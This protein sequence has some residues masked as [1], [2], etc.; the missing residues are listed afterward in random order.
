M[1]LGSAAVLTPGRGCTRHPGRR[2]RHCGRRSC[3]RAGW[4]AAADR[5]RL[6][7]IDES[8]CHATPSKEP[9]GVVT[10]LS[11]LIVACMYAYIFCVQ[12]PDCI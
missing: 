5:G 4:H 10:W 12:A 6:P 7:V 11:I 2:P 1:P 8:H 3:R 9:F